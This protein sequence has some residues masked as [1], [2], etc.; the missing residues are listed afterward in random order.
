MICKSKCIINT[1]FFTFAIFHV[2]LPHLIFL[3]KIIIKI[4]KIKIKLKLFWQK[5]T[6]SKTSV[7]MKRSCE[8]FPTYGIKNLIINTYDYFNNFHSHNSPV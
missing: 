6:D 2:Y 8:I 7:F 5:G 1:I 3:N 4:L